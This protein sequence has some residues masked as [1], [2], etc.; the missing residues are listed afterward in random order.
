MNAAIHTLAGA[1]AL[2]A[3]SADEAAYFEQHL[4]A[5]DGCAQEV[6]E[7]QEA[8]ATMGS[9]AA[10]A[11][12]AHLR[13]R[14]LSAAHEHP[15]LPPVTV[16]EPGATPISS[17]RS[18]RSR[19]WFTAT[20]GAVGVAAA[21]AAFAIA[22]ADVWPFTGHDNSSVAVDPVAQKVARVVHA[23]DAHSTAAHVRGGG[24][25]T[26][27]SSSSVGKTAVVLDQ[28]PE[29]DPAH[30]Y[31]MW[32]LSS[33]GAKP[34][35]VLPDV[36]KPEMVLPQVKPGLKIAITRE[37]AGGSAQPTMEPLAYVTTA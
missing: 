12:P 33:K 23:S 28:L 27:Y 10:E 25:L 14:V 3:L 36:A 4:D 31:Q 1:Y 21:V 34:L 37:P 6:A 26:V 17:A 9:T 13:A 2:D 22:G 30:D 35:A 29:L 19:R 32:L 7:L 15:Q 20:A 8:V 16:D 11:P 5:C 18:I 24:K